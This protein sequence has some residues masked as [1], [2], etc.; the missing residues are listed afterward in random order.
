M[1]FDPLNNSKMETT[2]TKSKDTDGTVDVNT[3][4]KKTN[5]NNQT[6]NGTQTNNGFNRLLESE[7]PESRLA[8]TTADGSGVIEYASNIKE[9]TNNDTIGN[10]ISTDGVST[11][12][13][14]IS[15][16]TISDITELETYVQTREGKS[17]SG[18]YSKMLTEYRKSLI[19]IEKE[20]FKE[21][22]QLFMLV[23]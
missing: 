5:I 14:D 21:M 23:Y 10:D 18:T 7:T 15:G 1:I 16:K 19:R 8:I 9:G 12:T 6:T 4:G 22:Q 3:D 13:T 11:D 20:M 17:G 2:Y